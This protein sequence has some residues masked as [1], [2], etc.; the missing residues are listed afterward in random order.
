MMRYLVG[1][2][3]VLALS[4]VPMVGC[5]AAEGA[6]GSGGSAGSGGFGGQGATGGSDDACVDN[7]CSCTAE[8]IRAAIIRG[9]GLYTFDCDGPTT[10]ITQA[11]IVIDND[12]ILDGEGNLTIDGNDDHRVLSVLPGFTAEL[13]GMTISGGYLAE[14]DPQGAGILNEGTL[15]ITDTVVQQ[16]MLFR[17]EGPGTP[18][19]SGIYSAGTLTVVNSGI[20]ENGIQPAGAGAG[21]Y[22]D[23]TL[24]LIGS[25]VSGNWIDTDAEFGCGIESIGDLT[26]IDSQVSDNDSG[27]GAVISASGTLTLIR[28]AVVANSRFLFGAIRSTGTA[29]VINSTVET[30]WDTTIAHNGTLTLIGSTVINHDVFGAIDA[31]EAFVANSL[32]IGVRGGS[33][34]CGGGV[35]SGGGNIESLGDT[36]N[37]TDPTDLVN[38]TAAEL[39]LGPLA[40]YGGPTQTYALLPGSVAIDRIPADECVD[41]D[42]DPLTMDQRGQPRPETGGTMCDVGA[43]EVQP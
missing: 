10:V 42:G 27:D 31:T 41:A 38:V 36:C 35:I 29:T 33:T 17:D 22:N 7:V 25:V 6:G 18:L 15:T 8:G 1:F 32:I 3:C 40:D 37:F 28:S 4:V 34:T 23:G 39:N 14:I 11:E 43:F 13:V 19:G 26:L 9:G 20:R 16:N 21:I 12:V 2:V 5:G 30:W 24:T